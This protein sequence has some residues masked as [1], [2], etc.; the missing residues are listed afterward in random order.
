MVVQEALALALHPNNTS[1][2]SVDIVIF[3]CLNDIMIMRR[4]GLYQR[5]KLPFPRG[6][7]TFRNQ[8]KMSLRVGKKSSEAAT[9]P[10]YKLLTYKR[11]PREFIHFC[12]LNSLT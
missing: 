4:T 3:F 9:L 11:P 8:L 5:V 12:S 7:N 10:K 6:G 2:N 1:S